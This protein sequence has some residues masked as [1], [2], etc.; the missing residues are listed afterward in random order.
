MASGSPWRPR[1]FLCSPLTVAERFC[2]S[3]GITACYRPSCS[4]RTVDGSSPADG[5]TPSRSGM[6][7]VAG[8]C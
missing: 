4:V 8:N 6:R 7:R 2:N 3:G 5:T 1:K